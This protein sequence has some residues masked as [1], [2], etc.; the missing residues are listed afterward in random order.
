MK[1]RLL[2]ILLLS[3][4]LLSSFRCTTS[5]WSFA[6]AFQVVDENDKIVDGLNVQIVPDLYNNSSLVTFKKNYNNA[7]GKKEF[8]Y[9]SSELFMCLMSQVSLDDRYLDCKEIQ[10]ILDNYSILISDPQNI[11]KDYTISTLRELI[12]NSEYKDRKLSIYGDDGEI[13]S[14]TLFFKIK[15]ERK[16][17]QQ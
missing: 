15:L 6:I 16:G 4:I 10:E 3:F 7:A 11:Y 17:A 14:N 1:K 9:Y 12:E 2:T 13:Y 8:S 5:V